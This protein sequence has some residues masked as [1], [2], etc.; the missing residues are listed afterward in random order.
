MSRIYHIWSAGAF[1]Q[2]GYT[3]P[4]YH[5]SVYGKSFLN[6]CENLAGKDPEFNKVFKIED[7]KPYYWGCRLYE[8]PLSGNLLGNGAET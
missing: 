7:S 6:A 2:E 3:P 4:R 5:A 1:L 8:A